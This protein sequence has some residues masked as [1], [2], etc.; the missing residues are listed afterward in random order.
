MHSSRG[1]QRL[2][3]GAGQHEDLGRPLEVVEVVEG[4]GHRGR[5]AGQAVVAHGEDRPV[6]HRRGQARTILYVS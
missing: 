5:R 1:V 4:L 6:A 2:A 3:A